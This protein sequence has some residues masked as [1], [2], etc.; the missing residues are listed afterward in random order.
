MIQGKIFGNKK[1]HEP[2]WENNGCPSNLFTNNKVCI[3]SYYLT[4]VW[5]LQWI[6]SWSWSPC[7]S[8]CITKPAWPPAAE[9]SYSTWSTLTP[10]LLWS[11]SPCTRSP[12]WLPRPSLIFQSR[13]ALTMRYLIVK[14]QMSK[15]AKHQHYSPLIKLF[16]TLGNNRKWT[17]YM[18]VIQQ[19]HQ[20]S[21]RCSIIT[22]V[23]GFCVEGRS[24]NTY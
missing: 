13:Y 23:A 7:C 20:K 12:N 3:T 4:Q 8:T 10:P 19:L 18:F 22:S 11:L 9:S 1:N 2:L 15:W 17:T 16:C 24:S 5:T 6:W 14:G 21:G